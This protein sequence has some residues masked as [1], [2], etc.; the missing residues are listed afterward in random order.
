MTNQ[1]NPGKIPDVEQWP[2]LD[3]CLA[4]G[5]AVSL[6]RRGDQAECRLVADDASGADDRDGL[7]CCAGWTVGE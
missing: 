2:R 4:Y 7:T 5:P 3:R 1:G 6:Y